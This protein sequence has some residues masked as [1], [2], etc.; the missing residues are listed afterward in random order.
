[1]TNGIY[2]NVEL[3][4]SI[5]LDLNNLPKEVCN[6]QFIRACTLVSQM[7]QKLAALRKGVPEDIAN[8][9]KTIET[10]KEQLRNAGC[11]VEDMTLAEFAE[12]YGKKD[13]AIDAD[14]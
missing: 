1:M 2:T 10:L 9:D 4:D 13:G 8:K 3:I 11:N 5:I 14:K 6:G 7:G 12:K